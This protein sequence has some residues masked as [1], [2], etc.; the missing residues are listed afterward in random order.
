MNAVVRQ[1]SRVATGQIDRAGGVIAERRK[2]GVP[3]RIQHT[4][5]PAVQIAGLAT[6]QSDL[7]TAAPGGL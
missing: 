6:L 1:P 4:A 3:P 7:W 5:K 2:S